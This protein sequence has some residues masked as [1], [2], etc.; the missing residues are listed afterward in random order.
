MDQAAAVG[1]AVS[2]SDEVWMKASELLTPDKTI[3]RIEDKAKFIVSTVT[4]VGTLLTGLGLF[5]GVRLTSTHLGQ[6]TAVASVILA[7]LSVVLAVGSL[8]VGGIRTVAP[9]NLAAVE[10]WYMN[11][12]GRGRAVAASGLLLVLA[13]VVGAVATGSTIT[14]GEVNQPSLNARIL[15]D[16]K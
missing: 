9:S 1:A 14:S 4:L 15:S 12:I 2:A 7:T 10:A 5:A 6:V 16:G 11:Q 8:V 3:Q 13:F